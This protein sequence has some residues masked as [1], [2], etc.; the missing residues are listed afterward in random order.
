[1]TKND[2]KLDVPAEIDRLRREATGDVIM[3]LS[4]PLVA[5]KV[6][7]LARELEREAKE[8]KRSL[9][10]L[11]REVDAA[12][13]EHERLQASMLE[14]KQEL[15]VAVPD[16]LH[17]TSQQHAAQSYWQTEYQKRHDA[18]YGYDGRV[19]MLTAKVQRAE[20]RIAE[21]ERALPELRAFAVSGESR[22][23]RDL[24]LS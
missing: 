21:L 5:E 4:E 10:E 14:A 16:W 22:R 18:W 13:V 12:L 1:M 15:A 23:I 6:Q 2:Q 19:R 11:R 20:A 8:L 24:V 9:P 3:A 17:A 7:A